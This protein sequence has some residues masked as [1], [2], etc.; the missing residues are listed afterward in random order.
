MDYLAYGLTLRSDHSLPFLPQTK[1]KVDFNLRYEGIAERASSTPDYCEVRW[2]R[3]GQDWIW[4]YREPNGPIFKLIFPAP[5]DQLII[6]YSRGYGQDIFPILMGPGLG[7][8]LH[9]RGVPLLHGAAVVIGEDAVLLSGHSGMGKSTLTVRLVDAGCSL[10]TED[11]A[12]LNFSSEEIRIFPGYPALQL[13]AD[14]LLNLDYALDACPP[15]YPGLPA[16]DKRW[17]DVKH[18]AGGSQTSSA[19]LRVI[20]LLSGRLPE[21]KVPEIT[22]LAPS[23]AALALLEHLY[24]QRWLQRPPETIISLCAQIAERLPVRRVLVPEG[25]DTVAVSAQALMADAQA[26]GLALSPPEKGTS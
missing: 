23:Q 7:A 4:N 16:D 11:L 25:L 8:A 20:Y 18:L 21:L 5:G 26:S 6:R 10:L 22:S 3:E 1:A 2:Y 14:T 24:G 13:R 15:V 9:L 12:P 17:L 19:R